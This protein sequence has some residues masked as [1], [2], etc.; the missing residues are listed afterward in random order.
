MRLRAFVPPALLWGAYGIAWV[1]GAERAADVLVGGQT[2]PF[3]AACGAAF[4]C[5]RLLAITVAPALAGGAILGSAF[6]RAL[7]AKPRVL[8][9]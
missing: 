5:L 1:A 3:A 9:R 8:D 4:L 6:G 7:R 2:D